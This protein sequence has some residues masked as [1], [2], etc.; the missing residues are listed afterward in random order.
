[1]APHGGARRF[2]EEADLN[3]VDREKIASANW[4]RICAHIRR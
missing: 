2:L 1:L 4:D 3:E